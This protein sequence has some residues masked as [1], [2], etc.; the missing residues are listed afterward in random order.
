MNKKT[1]DNVSNDI[2]NIKKDDLTG[3]DRF[4]WN[5]IVSWAS[6]LVLIFS[7]FIM[8][9]LVD[10]KVGQAALGIWDFGWSFV[11]Y[12]S[13]VGLGMGACFNRY[14]AKHRA[15]GE[16]TLLN[17]VANSAV[18]VQLIF[19][20]VTI[21]CTVLFYTL[22]PIYFGESLAENTE[23]AQW[24]VLFLGL[25]VAVRMSSGSASGLLTGYHRW[26]IHNA[27]HA[28][29]SLLS[30]TLMVAALYFTNLGVAGMAIGYLLST[31]VFESLR[32]VFVYKI[33][34]EFNFNLRMAN[35]NTCRQ[36]LKFGIKSMLSNIPPIIL[37][38]TISIMLVSAIGPAALAVFARPMALTK[39]IKTF[40]TK[41]TL[42]LT[43]TTGSMQGAGDIKAVQALFINTTK[44]SFAFALPSLGFL[45]IYGDV[46]LNYWMGPEYALWPL[47]MI[48]ACGQLLPMGQDTSIR[49]LMGLNQHG[50]ISI[51]AFIAIFV[52]FG[53]G[54]YFSGLGDWELT[55]AAL[56]FVIPM[57]IVYGFIVPIYTCR[58]LK[59][60]WFGYVHNSFI[61]PLIYIL[62]FLGLLSWSRHLYQSNE[63]LT[64]SL[65]LVAAGLITLIIYFVY[66]VPVKM[67]NKLL[68]RLK[69]SS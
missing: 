23:I 17:N 47:M 18:F 21:L 2:E 59:L 45:F 34:K 35:W 22:L 28:G 69:L 41:F 13:L 3:Q 24:V 15:A 66:L 9:R 14:V 7:G 56:L 65:F 67:Q 29:D 16:I 52:F 46:I 40:M 33:C 11:S 12:L 50:R 43:P 61:K 19:S 44:L 27:L 60:S 58:E 57:N 49:I 55:T 10:D 39:Q 48:L 4:A 53:I 36:M 6:Q 62:P 31:I 64:A 68:L 51:V 5:L 37:L 1:D 26:D 25:S 20:V 54:L 38:Q 8:P 30:I 63:I 32:F 42:M